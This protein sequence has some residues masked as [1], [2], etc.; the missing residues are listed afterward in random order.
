MRRVFKILGAIALVLIAVFQD[1]L[2]EAMPENVKDQLETI[3]KKYPY[4][5]YTAIGI[6][7]LI[8]IVSAIWGIDKKSKN[9]AEPAELTDNERQRFIKLLQNRYALRMAQKTGER[10]ALKLELRYTLNGI[11]QTEQLDI[12]A[13]QPG[14]P[15]GGWQTL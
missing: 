12:A 11:Q 9:T 7:A 6:I 10:F 2:V 4:L 5:W 8:L 3:F 15:I 1:V 13:R 14:R